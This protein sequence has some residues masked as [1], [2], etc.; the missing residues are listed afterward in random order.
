MVTRFR[1]RALRK[2]VLREIRDSLGRYLAIVGI[3]ALGSGLFTGLKVTNTAMIYTCDRYLRDTDFFD[4]RLL[5]T[6]GFD[7]ET[8]ERLA[9]AD[10]VSAAEG[11]VSLDF[12][13]LAGDREIVYHALTLNE[14]INRPQLQTG[15]WP[16]A[17]N[18]CVIDGYSL[19][20][21]PV[22]S[23]ITLSDSND[24]DTLDAFSCRE[25][26]VVGTVRSPLYINYERGTTTLGSGSVSAFVIFPPEAFDTDYYTEIYLT[27]DDT[28]Y[29]YS[30]EYDA[31]SEEMIDALTPAAEAEALS[32]YERI[33]S[34]AQAELDDAYAEYEDGKRD[35]EEGKQEYEDGLQEVEDGKKKAEDGIIYAFWKLDKAEEELEK[36]KTTL[37]ETKTSLESQLAD[38]NAQRPGVAAQRDALAAQR[39]QLAA[40]GLPTDE[41][42]A[43]LAMLNGA[44]A[45]IDGGIAQIQGGLAQVADGEKQIADGRK[46]IA[47]NRVYAYAAYEDA[48]EEIAE[49][50]Q[51]LADAKIELEDAEKELADAEQELAD[52]QAELDDLEAPDTFVLGRDSN[53]GYV[54]FENDA[55]IVSGIARVFPFFFFAVAALVCVTTMNRMVDEERG[56][57]GILKALG[58]SEADIMSRYLVYSGSASVIGCALGVTAGSVI[59]PTVIWIAYGIMY[60]MPEIRLVFDAKLMLLSGGSYLLL[61]LAVTYFSCRSE[62]RQPAAELVRP[63]SPPPGKRILLERIGF[64]WK[65]CSF[66]LKVSFRNV[67]RYRKRL[68]MMVLGIGGC[69]GLLLTGFGIN[70]SITGIGDRQYQNVT[71]YDAE[72]TFT[73]DMSG[74]EQEFIDHCGDA[75]EEVCFLYSVSADCS[76]ELCSGSVS[77]CAV[78]DFAGLENLI[79]FRSEG[80]DVPAPEQGGC[81]VSEN[82]ADRY[83]VTVGDPITVMVDETV[84][85]VLTVSGIYENV[86]YNYVYTTLDELR[87][88][89]DELPLKL[90]YLNIPDASDVHAAGALIADY[91]GVGALSLSADANARI[92]NMLSSMKYIVILI[93]CC[94]GALAFIVLFNLTNINVQERI[95]EIATIKV[96]GFRGGETAS[97]VFRE[98]FILT[99]CGCLAGIPMGI[100]LHDFV[101]SQVKID[102]MVFHTVRKPMSY[103]LAMAITF[104][105]AACVD[106]FMRPRLERINMA[107]AL[108]SVE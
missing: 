44:L 37:A 92:N 41:A 100:W 15:R 57:L 106:R 9:D 59:F 98:N 28:P 64:I 68:I 63:K 90:C 53:V 65:R 73:G 26:T 105:F 86:I 66:L 25:Y 21:L 35:Y 24:E 99:F 12:L 95:R 51:E 74:K 101:M 30:D 11:S 20:T 62:L 19:D 85:V 96:L 46:Q 13:A 48:L 3:I 79:R 69:T 16:E 67:F 94:A 50:E 34:D 104:V 5:S 91:D 54:C 87:P 88:F 6:L 56:Q 75:A 78:E 33:R 102:M 39:D 52:A 40:A 71:V 45:Q 60:N 108:K 49:A 70:D 42:D 81:L 58:Y 29:I 23:V 103:V 7:K 14:T 17:S 89:L 84:P 77:L 22:G 93:I 31:L 10:G 43:A 4:V 72:V 32:R 2:T 76:T 47:D 82:L 8:P 107:E 97:Y 38:L 80:E 1:K 55:A 61:A 83:G 27:L 36:Q 18:E